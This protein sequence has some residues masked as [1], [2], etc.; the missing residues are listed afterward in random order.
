[1]VLLPG[2]I[3]PQPRT[4]AAAARGATSA[5]LVEKRRPPRLCLCRGDM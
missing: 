4:L 1:M 2:A 3:L 5:L